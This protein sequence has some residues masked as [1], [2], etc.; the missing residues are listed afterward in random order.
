MGILWVS[1]AKPNPLGKDRL[2][3]F[4]PPRQLAAEWI[5]IKNIG[6]DSAALSKIHL[7]HI[8]YQSGCLGG[9]SEYVITLAGTLAPDEVMRVHSGGAIPLHEMNQEDVGDVA[10]HLFT[11]KHYIWNNACGDMVGLWDGQVWIDKTWYDPYPPEGRVLVRE[12]DK[13]V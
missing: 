4:T 9:K 7:N 1:Q 10:W 8:A 6:P 13:L 2:H 12:G 5:D 11:G 3:G